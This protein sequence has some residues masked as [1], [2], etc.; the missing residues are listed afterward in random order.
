MIIMI[1]TITMVFPDPPED[2]IG[3]SGGETGAADIAVGG[4]SGAAGSI[5]GCSRG[6]PQCSQNFFPGATSFPQ[7]V[8]N[9]I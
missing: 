2:L 3:T 4:V 7:D 5:G 9:D 6:V 1:P 8:Q